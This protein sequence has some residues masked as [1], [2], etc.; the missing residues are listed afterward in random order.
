M[1]ERV[2]AGLLD[3]SAALH[4][5]RCPRQVL[6]IR[7]GL[8]AGEWLGLELPRADKRLFT[9]VETDGCFADGVA[10]ATGCWF[11]RRTLRLVDHGK[12]AATFVDTLTRRAVR[13]WP[14]PLARSQALVSAPA[15]ANRWQAQLAAYQQM[16]AAELLRAEPVTLTVS[17]DAIISRPGR[18]A[19]CTRC[20]EEVM[21]ER[22]LLVGGQI[23]CR[24]CADGS[25]FR[26]ERSRTAPR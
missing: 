24:G 9:F 22:E 12:V 5:H 13:I 6:G 25:H 11:G 1:S 21:N 4:S 2:L 7:S 23:I 19:L 14:H 26:F 16:P 18:R 15:A 17:L 8:L 3:R 10:V 20:G